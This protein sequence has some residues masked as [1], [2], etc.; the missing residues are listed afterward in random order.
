MAVCV[1]VPGRPA[2][3]RPHGLGFCPFSSIFGTPAPEIKTHPK[4]VELVNISEFGMN[5][6]FVS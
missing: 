4:L 1:G 3:E 6:T 5:M 2:Y